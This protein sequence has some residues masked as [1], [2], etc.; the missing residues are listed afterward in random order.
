[1]VKKVVIKVLAGS[2]GSAGT[3]AA[4]YETL[5]LLS[6]SQR[7]AQAETIPLRMNRFPPRS[8]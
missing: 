1:M 3:A 8:I 6:G 4:D 7:L 2:G 5:P